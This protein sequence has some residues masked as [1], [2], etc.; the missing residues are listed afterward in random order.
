MSQANPNHREIEAYCQAYLANGGTSQRKAWRAAFPDSTASD[1][2]ADN[3]AYQMHANQEVQ[4]RFEQ[5]RQMEMKVFDANAILT[6]TEALKRLTTMTNTKPEDFLVFVDR[7][8]GHDKEGEPVWAKY[9]AGFVDFDTLPV[10]MRACVKS[11][12]MSHLGPKV[13]LYDIQSSIKQLADL[14]GWNIR[15]DTGDDVDSLVKALTKM[16]DSLPD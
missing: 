13:E 16:A 14:Q 1:K 11:I 5:I 3:K 12:S 15:G 8:V 4:A 9:P 10:E 6:K 2:N 7:Q